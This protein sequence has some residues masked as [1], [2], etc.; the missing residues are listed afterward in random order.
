MN[1]I[2]S[3]TRYPYSDKKVLDRWDDLGK[4]DAA[5]SESFDYHFSNLYSCHS[6]K[7]S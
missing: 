3:L 7:R 1:D 4:V 2:L 5:P 6:L